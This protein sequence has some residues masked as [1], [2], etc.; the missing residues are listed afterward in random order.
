MSAEEVAPPF[1]AAFDEDDD[2][3]FIAAEVRP[4]W[5]E[6]VRAANIKMFGEPL[7][8]EWQEIDFPT[9][10]PSDQPKPVVLPDFHSSEL[11]Q[12][13]RTLLE[14]IVESKKLV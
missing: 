1:V 13:F 5:S 12:K 2:W 7:R 10:T 3:G 4:P 14:E 11:G 8:K 9:F 6:R